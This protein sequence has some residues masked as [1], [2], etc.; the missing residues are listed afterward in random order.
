MPAIP[1]P[2][3]PRKHISALAMMGTW[4]QRMLEKIVMDDDVSKLLWY[5]TAD[6]L[7]RE[8]LTDDQKYQLA[9]AG[10]SRRRVYPTRYRPDVVSDQQSFI[11][12]GISGFTPQEAFAPYRTVA[13]RYVMGYLYFYIL[14][15]DSIM[16][17]DEGQRQDLLLQRIYDLFQDSS[18]FG[19]GRI[20]VGNLTEAWEQ[21]NKFG[22]YVLMMK[23]IDFT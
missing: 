14:V 3:K 23:V 15:D 6:A 2:D 18:D 1:I 10:D 17:C 13:D 9:T 22:G 7:S 21:N 8:D 11:G 20:S 5:N 4:K 16:D 19:M 12:L